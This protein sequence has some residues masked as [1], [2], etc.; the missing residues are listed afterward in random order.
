MAHLA[1]WPVNQEAISKSV[2]HQPLLA[3]LTP[4]QREIATLLCSLSLSYKEVAAKLEISEGT[5]RKHAE[6]LYRRTGVHSRAELMILWYR[7]K[8]H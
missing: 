4:R 5:I 8:L 7:G 6:N 1:D 3:S 2:D